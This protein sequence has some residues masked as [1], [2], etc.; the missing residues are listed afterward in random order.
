MSLSYKP[1]D[2]VMIQPKNDKRLV[3]DLLDYMGLD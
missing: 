1:G 2:I 3:E